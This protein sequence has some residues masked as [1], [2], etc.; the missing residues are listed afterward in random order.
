MVIFSRTSCS[1]FWLRNSED[2]DLPSSVKGKLGGPS[3]RRLPTSTTS[4]VLQAVC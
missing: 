2:M 1:I 3:Q 4:L